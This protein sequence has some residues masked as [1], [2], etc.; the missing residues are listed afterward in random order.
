LALRFFILKWKGADILEYCKLQIGC[1]LIIL[2]IAF[3]YCEER[4]RFKQH[5]KLS[6][7]DLML[8]VGMLAVLFDGATAYTV[9][10]LDSVNGTLNIVL[11]LFFLLGLD[12]FIFLLFLYMISITTGLPGR[13]SRRF[14]LYSPFAVNVILVVVNIPSLK[15]HEGEISNYSMGVSAYTCFIMAG[16]YIVLSLIIFFG[17]WRYIEKHKRMSIFTYLS[18][19]ACVTAYQMFHPQALL[20]SI[21]VTVIVLGAYVNQENPTVSELAH[22]HDEMIMGFAT[23]V[24]NKDGSTGGHIRRTTTYVKLLA[25]ELRR[26]GYYRNELTKD[27]MKNLCMAAPMHDIGKISIPDVILQKPGRLTEEEF[28]AI[29]S[30]AESGGR[31]IQETFGN[32]ENKEYAQMAYEVARFHHEKWNGKGYPDGLKREE[33]PLAARIMAIADVFDALSEKR[34]YKDAM[35]MDKCFEIIQEGSG[36]EFDPVLVE[37]FLDIRSQVEEVHRIISHKE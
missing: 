25:E 28:T 20:S 3:V 18:V 24:E 17:R 34:C 33:I 4:R 31:I 26:R 37:V 11:H 13:Q 2:Y 9:N 5:N 8:S 29:K 22:Y 27:F 12:S 30:H 6:L 36:Q 7:F 32:L 23:L 16:V 21:C 15:Y 1:M 19:L 14:L 10:H 35:P